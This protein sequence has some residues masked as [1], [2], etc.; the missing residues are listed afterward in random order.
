MEIQKETQDKIILLQNIQRQLQIVSA[1]RQ[2][3]D[4]EVLQIDAALVDLEK[5]SGKA[6]KAIGTMFIE[7]NPADLVKE[8][9]E[10]RITINARLDALKK[11]EEKLRI[12]VD[13][14]HAKVEKEL[15]GKQTAAS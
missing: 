5:A 15:S 13:E 9:N 7:S 2:R 3:F 10:S 4:V 14:L 11:Q 1:Q 6:F 12:K 8:L